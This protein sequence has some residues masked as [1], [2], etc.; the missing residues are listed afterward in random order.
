MALSTI[1]GRLTRA[2]PG[3][4]ARASKEGTLKSRLIGMV[5]ALAVFGL[6]VAACAEEKTPGGG[7]SPTAGPAFESELI[8]SGVLT[9]G[10][11]LDYKPFEW[12][13]K[14]EN[15]SGASA[16]GQLLKFLLQLPAI[17]GREP[18]CATGP[19]LDRPAR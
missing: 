14:G 6:I 15:R 7:E 4:T 12:V 18:R 2:G 11:C 8:T 16:D 13:A 10:S 9:V 3:H 19:H 5:A 1:M 17:H